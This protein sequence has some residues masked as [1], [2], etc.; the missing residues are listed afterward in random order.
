MGWEAIESPKPSDAR[1]RM[2]EENNA[3]TGLKEYS[4]V[5]ITR[6]GAILEKIPVDLNH[7]KINQSLVN[8]IE[9]ENLNGYFHVALN[10]VYE[11]KYGL[12][13]I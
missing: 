13:W 2:L 8:N 1:Y 10:V 3:E 7:Y 11:K 4:I 6:Y 5:N 12:I 9:V